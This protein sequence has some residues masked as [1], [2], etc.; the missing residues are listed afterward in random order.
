[1]DI[2]YNRR[3]EDASERVIGS[4][5]PALVTAAPLYEAVDSFFLLGTVGNPT[6]PIQNFIQV[7]WP[8]GLHPSD[9]IVQR[10]VGEKSDAQYC[11]ES[12]TVPFS[13]TVYDDFCFGIQ[14][15]YNVSHDF[16]KVAFAVR[17]VRDVEQDWCAQTRS[18]AR[19]RY[20]ANASVLARHDQGVGMKRPTERFCDVGFGAQP[21]QSPTDAEH[22][23]GAHLAGISPAFSLE[24]GV[25]PDGNR[26]G[27]RA[28]RASPGGNRW[29]LS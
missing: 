27:A 28:R 16:G 10:S 21:D 19:V 23:G 8:L 13:T 9:S 11:H 3:V 15:V 6:V 1:M 25:G 29:D 14:S 12:C 7:N 22:G 4:F 18:A 2:P 17:R 24:V 26:W 5:C 20:A